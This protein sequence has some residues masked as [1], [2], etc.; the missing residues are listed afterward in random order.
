[1][2]IWRTSPSFKALSQR[3]K[4][5]PKGPRPSSSNSSQSRASRSTDGSSAQWQSSASRPD[6]RPNKPIAA[7][8]LFGLLSG[9]LALLCHWALEPSVDLDARDWLLLLLLGLGPL[10]AAFFLW[11][12]ALKLGDVRQIGILSYLTPLASTLLLMQVSGRALSASVA[13]A[14]A[15]I[16]GAALL[17]TRPMRS[18]QTPR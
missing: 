16:I 5:A 13:L 15:L 2:P 10:G 11:D 12:K 1:M 8:G 4:A 9:L 7:V 3:K 17:G 14:A 6:N 18:T